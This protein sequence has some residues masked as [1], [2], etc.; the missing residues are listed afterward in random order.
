LTV[1]VNE[2]GHEVTKTRS[3]P[4]FD[5]QKDPV[6]E[7][8]VR[9][10]NQWLFVS[11]DGHVHPIDVP[12]AKVQA[13]SSW[14]LVSDGDRA[15]SWRIGGCN[16]WPHHER[17]GSTAHAPACGYARDPGEECGSTTGVARLHARVSE[18]SG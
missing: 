14:P 4:F 15:A 2:E 3:E 11:F 12:A 16:T 10:G 17:D 6:T 8:G 7:K 13:G 1:V 5:P 9:Y 18:E